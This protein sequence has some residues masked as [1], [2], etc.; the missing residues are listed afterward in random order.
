MRYAS[1]RP[2]HNRRVTFFHMGNAPRWDGSLTVPT[3]RGFMEDTYRLQLE[4]GRQGTITQS[5][6]WIMEESLTVYFEG[7]G[8]LQRET[9]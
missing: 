7:Q 2:K 1:A 9:L 5:N 4:D 3:T 6:V 8:P